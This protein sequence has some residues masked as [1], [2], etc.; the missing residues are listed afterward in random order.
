MVKI[1]LLTL[2]L[3][4][5]FSLAVTKAD[6]IHPRYTAPTPPKGICRISLVDSE[7]IFYSAS[8]TLIKNSI[9]T[10]A[11][12]IINN[13]DEHH[14]RIYRI[15][16]SG[17]GA[18]SLNEHQILLHPAYVPGVSWNHDIAL[19]LLSRSYQ[20]DIDFISD[21]ENEF[22]APSD[23]LYAFWYRRYESRKPIGTVLGRVVNQQ[24]L[25]LICSTRWPWYRLA[26]HLINNIQYFS[27]QCNFILNDYYII[28]HKEKSHDGPGAGDS[29][30]P[31][32]FW[33][34]NGNRF[35]AGVILK[36]NDSIAMFLRTSAYLNWI[37]HSI[38]W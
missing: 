21:D 13:P 9:I 19:I 10:A 38:D 36:G 30:G 31:L 11:H 14:N 3:L 37:L 34:K 25:L 33:D 12:I 7:G 17:I 23:G 26:G 20:T 35:L 28:T 4:F 1:K 15:Y 8:G 27:D 16:C 5:L 32:L 22:A 2:S 29:G 6:G 24:E 18:I